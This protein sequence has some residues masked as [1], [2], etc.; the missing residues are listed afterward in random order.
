MSPWPSEQSDAPVT[1]LPRVSGW[2]RRLRLQ[3][4][5]PTVVVFIQ[6]AG[7]LAWRA[8][9][10]PAS[11]T[12]LDAH[13]DFA[14]WCAASPGVSARLVLSGHFLHSLGLPADADHGSAP[15]EAA[16]RAFA[17]YHGRAAEGWVLAADGDAV[18]TY[19]CALHGFDLDTARASAATH[20]IVLKSS[21]P[22]WA[23]VLPAAAARA[24]ALARARRATLAWVEGTLVTCLDL[25]VGRL[26]GIQQ[27]HLDEASVDA[28]EELLDRRRTEAAGEDR[29][30]F[31][32]GW[33]LAEYPPVG[34]GSWLPVGRL[35]DK[36]DA[37][38]WL[39]ER[40]AGVLR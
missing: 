15:R 35:D 22:L 17:R 28:F 11:A 21:S 18:S 20:G 8:D 36:A 39:F 34:S 2:A 40:R 5:R 1:P 29:L 31:A 10:S 9:A 32:G 13:G 7:V 37:A 14:A 6:P 26:A 33:G 27:R 4:R 3:V 24:P 38:G 12:R 19:A 16:R 30:V 23:E 25:D